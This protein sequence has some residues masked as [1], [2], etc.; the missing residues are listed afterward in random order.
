MAIEI[1]RKFLVRKDLL[2][3]AMTQVKMIQGYLNDDK[4]RTIR[5]RIVEE[6]AYLTVKGKVVGISRPEFEYEVPVIDAMAMMKLSVYPPVEKVRHIV[7]HDG[8]KW[9]VDVFSG[10]NSGLVLAE[11]ELSHENEHVNL[12]SWVLEEVSGD[13]RY[14]NS[15]L[16]KNPYASWEE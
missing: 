12:P 9:E 5:I 6:K 16:S 4:E 8:K 3:D 7:I 2:P 11:V 14:Y 1:E 10:L 13:Q 15:Q